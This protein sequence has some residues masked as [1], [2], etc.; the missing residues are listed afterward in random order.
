MNKKEFFVVFLRR[1]VQILV[2]AWDKVCS[3]IE[4]GGLR[5]RKIGSFNQA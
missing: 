2:V 1:V 4:I 5:I 3:P